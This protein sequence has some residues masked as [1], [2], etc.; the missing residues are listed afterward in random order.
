MQE[1]T[2]GR[3]LLCDSTEN[4]QSGR[5]CKPCHLRVQRERYAKAVG[6][7]KAKPCDDCG[8]SFV[9]K[10]NDSR[11]RYCSETCNQRAWRRR[12]GWTPATPKQPK[13]PKSPASTIWIKA[14]KC[15]ELFVARRPNG[16]RCPSC[17]TQH[18]KRKRKAHAARRLARV[19]ASTVERFIHEDIYERDGWRCG[20]CKQPTKRNAVVPHPKAPT[21]DHIVPLAKGGEHTRAN[22][23]CAHFECNY[24]KSDKAVTSGEQLRLVG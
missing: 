16:E 15:S 4:M 9:P 7:P 1:T 10:I 6:Q 22:V 23:Q 12:N 13:Q 18:E 24:L 21:L 11:K 14:C 3:C 8:E 5:R 2:R 19:R 17:R 20:I